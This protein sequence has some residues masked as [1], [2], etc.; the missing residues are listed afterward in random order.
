VSTATAPQRV[1]EE[2]GTAMHALIADL[3]PICRSITG[4]GLRETLHRLE[5]YIPLTVH[6]VATGT[7]V[8]DWTVP[9]EWNIKDAYVKNS[10]GERVVDF[11]RSNLHVLN[12]SIP[13]RRTVSLAELRAHCFTLPEHP[14]WIPYR[15]SYYEEAWGFC[16]THRQLEALPEDEYEVVIDSTLVPGHLT[17]GELVLPGETS[18]EI[19]ISCHACHPSLC[20][21][22]L[23]GVA[24]ATFLA[25]YLDGQRRR[26][27]YRFLFIPGTIGSITWLARNEAVVGRI[28]HGLVLASVGDAG[29]MHYK[30]SR[31]GSAEID[32]AV[33]VVLRDT[34]QPFELMD[35]TPYGYDERQYCSPGYDLAVGCVSRTPYARYPEYHTSADD[36]M[37]VRPESLADSYATCLAVFAV[38]EGNEMLVNTNP[39]GEPQLGRRGLYEA[40]GGRAEERVN[41]TALLWVLN[42]SDGRH[43]L[44]D[45]AERSGLAFAWIRR[46]A[47]L[48]KTHKL[49][50]SR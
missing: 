1:T 24:V 49:L 37:F 5:A 3:Y 11:R 26:H 18:D 47:N 25:R 17:Y 42:L 35:F 22:N 6:E 14:D 15:T 50:E 16:L 28:K 33:A 46:A 9:R 39:R 32:R 4:D 34:A 29:P 48:L 13:V 30:R 44:L 40:I 19:L 12:Y 27:T 41:E 7:K 31:R 43:S 45:I 20:N 23:S 10:R 2:I 38:L 21:D 8:L 36:L